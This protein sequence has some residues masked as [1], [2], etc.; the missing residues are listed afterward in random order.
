MPFD[1]KGYQAQAEEL[2]TNHLGGKEAALRSACSRYYYAAFHCAMEYSIRKINFQPNGTAE[3][4]GA[5]I[6]H[7]RWPHPQIAK[8]PD[9][10][11][12]HRNTCD[13][14]VTVTIDVIEKTTN[15]AKTLAANIVVHFQK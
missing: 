6:A 5:L 4:H 11:R 14:N 15:H 12:R 10:L 13:Y 7:L 8:Y 3:D 9:T 1:W 2:C